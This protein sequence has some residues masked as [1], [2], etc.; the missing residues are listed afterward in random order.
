VRLDSGA[1]GHD[2]ISARGYL[3]AGLSWLLAG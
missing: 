2:G 1:T 3:A